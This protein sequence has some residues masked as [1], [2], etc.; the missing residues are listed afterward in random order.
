MEWKFIFLDEEAPR[1]IGFMPFEVLGTSVYDYYH[2]DDLDSMVAGLCN[3]S[4]ECN[5]IR[6]ANRQVITI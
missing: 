4:I 3:N 2:W 5:L 6:I 1:W